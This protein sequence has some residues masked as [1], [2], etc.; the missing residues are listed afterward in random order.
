M[1]KAPLTI[2][3]NKWLI[4]RVAWKNGLKNPQKCKQTVIE[5]LKFLK[6]SIDVPCDQQILTDLILA[7]PN[8]Q[9]ELLDTQIEFLTKASLFLNNKCRMY[10]WTISLKL[11]T[12][13]CIFS[14]NQ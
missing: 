10:F 12:E 1:V 5:I 4:E 3:A 11:M 9:P 14:F 2:S 13:V 7:I 6:N 8:D